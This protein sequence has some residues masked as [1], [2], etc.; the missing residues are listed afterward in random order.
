TQPTSKRASLTSLAP[1]RLIE[2]L[3]TPLSAVL[4]QRE[5]VVMNYFSNVVDLREFILCSEPA[6]G[7]NI[8]VKM[9]C[10]ASERLAADNGTRVTP[11]D[12]MAHGLFD[13]IQETISELTT[14]N[15]KPFIAQITVCDAKKKAGSPRAARVNFRVGAGYEFQQVHNIGYFSYIVN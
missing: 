3:D 2:L 14:V 15:R 12:Y 6:A 10:Y 11:V 8:S 13:D 9:C 5:D 1:N 4:Q 7:V